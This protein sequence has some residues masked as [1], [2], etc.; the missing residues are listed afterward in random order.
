METPFLK[1]QIKQI[2]VHVG[3]QDLAPQAS[4]LKI[5][6]PCTSI[7]VQIIEFFRVESGK[8]IT[9]QLQVKPRAKD[10]VPKQGRMNQVVNEN[11]VLIGHFR[12]IVLIY[13]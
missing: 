9:I 5:V 1:I 13:D 4:P 12:V 2:I 3:T 6:V 8:T 10:V 7:R 11:K